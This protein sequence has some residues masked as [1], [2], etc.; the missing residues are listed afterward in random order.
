MIIF[1]TIADRPR[2]WGDVESVVIKQQM[3]DWVYIY[4]TLETITEYQDIS[5]QL[6]ELRRLQDEFYRK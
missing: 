3:I 5:P 6:A 4:D 1:K 2:D